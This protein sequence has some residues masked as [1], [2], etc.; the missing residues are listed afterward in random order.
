[1]NCEEANQ[2]DMVDYLS[3][4]GFQ[5]TKQEDLITGTF[6]LSEMKKQPPS[7]FKEVKMYG[8]IM[9]SGQEEDW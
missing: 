3:F 2:I 5:P 6:L 7:K 9:E 1:M 4:L 8:M